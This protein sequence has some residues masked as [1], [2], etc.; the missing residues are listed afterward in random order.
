VRGGERRVGVSW[1]KW[2][3]EA[4]V[5]ALFAPAEDTWAS[6]R[7]GGGMKWGCHGGSG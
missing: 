2:G 4:C 1:E 5:R 6:G 7:G 3:V